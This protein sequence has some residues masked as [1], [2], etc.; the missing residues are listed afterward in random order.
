MAV[1]Y[2]QF[3]IQVCFSATSGHPSSC[4]SRARFPPVTLTFKLDMSSIKIDRKNMKANLDVIWSV[5]F[6]QHSE[7]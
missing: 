4:R 3:S 5:K 7:N 1:T 6:H 2:L